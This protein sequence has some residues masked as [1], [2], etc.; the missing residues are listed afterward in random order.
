MKQRNITIVIGILLLTGLLI[1][2]NTVNLEYTFPDQTQVAA[3]E[4]VPWWAAL[5]PWQGS[6][7]RSIRVHQGLDLQ[8]GLQVVLEA[9]LPQGQELQEGAMEAARIIVDNR[10]NGLGVT[11]P[12][13]QLQ[14]SN[15]MIVELPGISDPELAIST[16]RET[17]LLEFV[18]AGRTPI[19]PG[20][21]IQTSLGGVEPST[22]TQPLTG[23]NEITTTDE[24][25][26]SEI[27][28]AGTAPPAESYPTIITGSDLAQV[29]NAG[30]NPDRRVVEIVF[31][32][33]PESGQ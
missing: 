8:G 11:E 21:T 23:T 2:I 32:L 33:K 14:G 7:Q 12:L 5:L 6:Q 3:E 30:F 10:V 22:S 18:D 20:T 17:G 9:D 1:W 4:A 19:L 28:E 15:R 31:S 24:L 27:A 13:V 16:L 25:T 29:S 26:G